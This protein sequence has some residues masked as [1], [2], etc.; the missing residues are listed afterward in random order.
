[1]RI[2]WAITLLLVNCLFVVSATTINAILESPSAIPQKPILM[3]ELFIPDRAQ[4]KSQKGHIALQMDKLRAKIQV[5]Q[6]ASPLQENIEILPDMSFN[7]VSNELGEVIPEKRHLLHSDNP[8]WDFFIGVGKFWGTPPEHQGSKISLP[9][10]IVEKNENCVHNGV[11]VIELGLAGSSNQF[12]YQ[13][14]S[15][16]CAYFKADFWG[17][18]TAHYTENTSDSPGEIVTQ[19]EAEKHARLPWVALDE[20]AKKLPKIKIENL[21]LPQRI[22]LTDMSAYG[23]LYKDIHYVSSCPTRAGNYPF[24]EQ[25]VL[26]SYSTAKSLFAGLAMFYLE[27]HYGNVFEQPVD[28]WI[29]QCSDSQWQGVTFGHLLDM[30]TGN[31]D[32]AQYGVDEASADKLSF[33]TAKTNEGRI[34]YACNHYVRKRSPGST[35]VYHSSD[36]YLLGVGLNKFIKSKLGENADIF[37]DILYK[38]IF[39]PLGLSQVSAKTRRTQGEAK[40]PYTGY[41]LFFNRHDLVKLSRY[42]QRQSTSTESASELSKN[43]LLAGLQQAPNNRGATTDYPNIRYQHGFWGR[44]VDAKF[45]CKSESWIPFMSGYGGITLALLGNNNT[46]YYVSDSYQFNWTEA[47]SELDKLNSV[48]SG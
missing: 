39:L 19:Y 27:K 16:T 10:A 25:L 38:Q 3:S 34:A 42:I 33:F 29:E 13:I 2:I 46:Y 37:T 17:T 26:P 40:Q 32:S 8:N 5:I 47:L 18:G 28:R 35:F 43:Y 4:K 24:C 36:T 48:C 9:F 22:A 45:K 6:S 11:L 20:L 41:G 1:M 30:T 14:S 12:Y 31:F 21:A 23:V 44:K 15:E 7:W